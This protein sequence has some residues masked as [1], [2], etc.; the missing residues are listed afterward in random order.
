VAI[1]IFDTAARFADPA[2]A[3]VVALA[4]TPMTSSAMP[5]LSAFR[6]TVAVPPLRFSDPP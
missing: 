2:R 4:A 5:V 6:L 1:A 3:A